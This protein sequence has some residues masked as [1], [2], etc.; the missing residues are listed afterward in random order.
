MEDRIRAL[1]G[2]SFFV[3]MD[4][5]PSE[6][7][8]RLYLWCSTEEAR[9]HRRQGVKPHDRSYVHLSLSRE[10]AE[11]RSRRV[12]APCVVEIL[13]REAHDQGI[14]FHLRGEVIL[15][16]AI[17]AEFVG[18]ITGLDGEEES[19]ASVPGRKEAGEASAF[20]RR[21]RRATRSP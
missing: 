1:Y 5:D 19:K 15:T 2:H 6:P 13:A 11:A 17:P 7:P 20:G 3:D 9:R 4:G 18:E 8:E 12:D 14:S 10:A 21:M 16:T